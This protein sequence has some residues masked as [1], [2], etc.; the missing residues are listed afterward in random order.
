MSTLA[1]VLAVPVPIFVFLYAIPALWES[2]C[3]RSPKPP[4]PEAA[5]GARGSSRRTVNPARR[6]SW[7]PHPRTYAEYLAQYDHELGLR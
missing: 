1:V 2:L 4:I 6:S 3:S 7:N 5:L